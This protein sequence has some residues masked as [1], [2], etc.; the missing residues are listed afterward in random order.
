MLDVLLL[1]VEVLDKEVCAAR[2]S[3]C[4]AGCSA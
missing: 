4:T 2:G 3:T 1:E